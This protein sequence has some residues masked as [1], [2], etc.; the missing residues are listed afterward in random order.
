MLP[1]KHNLPELDTFLDTPTPKRSRVLEPKASIPTPP[2]VL[3][4]S[5]RISGLSSQDNSAVTD[6]SF[7]DEK[8]YKPDDTPGPSIRPRQLTRLSGHSKLD[9]SAE[10]AFEDVDAEDSEYDFDDRLILKT[11]WLSSILGLTVAIYHL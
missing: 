4:R 8:A 3:R 1:P 2:I 10:A 11:T 9:F 5:S 7:L 6:L